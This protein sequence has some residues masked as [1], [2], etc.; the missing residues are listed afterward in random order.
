[1]LEA[2]RTR[3]ATQVF[4]AGVS[5]PSKKRRTKAAKAPTG[6]ARKPLQ[7]LQQPS[8]LA[9]D[10][11][12][13]DVFENDDNI[14]DDA[15]LYPEG[16]EQQ[17]NRAPSLPSIP[18]R[19]PSLHLSSDDAGEPAREPEDEEERYVTARWRA[20][21]GKDSLAHHQD[22]DSKAIIDHWTSTGLRDWVDGV[23]R[24]LASE[25]PPQRVFV[26]SLTATVYTSKQSKELRLA[27]SLRRG[28]P[29]KCNHV[30]DQAGQLKETLSPIEVTRVDFD[31]KL[32][33]AETP[34]NAQTRNGGQLLDF[35][36][37]LAAEV[38][39]GNGVA[40]QIRDKWRCQDSKCCNHSFCCWASRT[41][42]RADRFEDHYPANSNIVAIWAREI[43]LGDSSVEAPSDN[44]RLCLANARARA[45]DE[46]SQRRKK[47]AASDSGSGSG[48]T[49]DKCIR[50]ITANTM[51][52]L[53][54]SQAL[55]RP[56]PEVAAPAGPSR[57]D[58]V[59]MTYQNMAE[60]S[61]HTWKFFAYWESKA[62]ASQIKD[63][64]KV[65]LTVVR[66]TQIDIIVLIDP[67]DAGM[68][69]SV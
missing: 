21:L 9:L 54:Q 37:V 10:A 60:L 18:S 58:W 23:V 44:I 7:E 2:R 31:L 61:T 64:N 57:L 42:G 13:D 48:D 14:Q 3:K 52:Q 30:K 17:E 49:F 40:I 6:K 28:D 51:Q 29:V 22:F 55:T 47:R 39:A 62:L 27:K 65:F 16:E 38:A 25:R 12:A 33:L 4:D 8:Q 32:Q 69:F 59:P 41:P 67:S 46:K 50:L 26:N 43:N 56:P 11:Q 68:P 36:E 15:E 35:P 34:Q 53:A 5:L 45:A 19:L 1:M 66:D 63:I 20:F 24:D